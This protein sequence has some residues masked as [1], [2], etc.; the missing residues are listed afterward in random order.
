MD[1]I[2]PQAQWLLKQYGT[3]GRALAVA[4]SFHRALTSKDGET[5][6]EDLRRYC[7]IYDTTAAPGRHGVDVSQ[8]LINEGRRQA[9]LH[10]I[11]LLGVTA[12]E[13]TIEGKPNDERSDRRD[14]D[15]PEPR[16][17]YTP[18]ADPSLDGPDP[19]SGSAGSASGTGSAGDDNS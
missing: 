18:S 3:P 16:P 2:S 11:R 5:V 8:T 6:L 12:D 13:L 4:G 10:V 9:Y 19:A 15:G 1:K 7:N 14:G 17:R